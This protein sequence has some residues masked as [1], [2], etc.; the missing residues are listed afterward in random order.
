[1]QKI[2][3]D[4]LY[5]VQITMT[6]TMNY[7]HNGNYDPTHE[8]EEDWELSSEQYDEL[9]KEDKQAYLA[10]IFSATSSGYC[11]NAVTKRPYDFK[12]NHPDSRKL[13]AIHNSQGTCGRK[14]PHKMYYDTPEQYERHRHVRLQ[15]SIIDAFYNRQKDIVESNS[16]QS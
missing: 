4:Y 16:E 7:K 5:I 8:P 2:E 1:M 13:F 14:D 15:R 11:Y 10:N 6:E 12:K 9:A 3:M